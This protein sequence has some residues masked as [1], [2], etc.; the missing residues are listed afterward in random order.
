MSRQLS[1]PQNED[2]KSDPISNE[3]R[4]TLSRRD[5]FR[6]LGAGVMMLIPLPEADAQRPG[7]GRR[8]RGNS[9]PREI[10]AWI[11][12]AENGTVTVYSGK[13]EVGQN[14]RTSLTQA[15]AEELRIPVAAIQMVLGDTD[16]TP[17]D[18]GTF[19]S[20]TTPTMA[21]QLHRAAAAAREAIIGLAAQQWQVD[22]STIVAV[23]G[24]VVHSATNQ[25][26]GYGDVVKGQR[27]TQTIDDSVATTSAKDWKV[28][29]TSVPKVD[30]RDFVTGRHRY[31][32]DVKRDGM[33][34]GKVLR[35]TAF[36]A[37][38][39][40]IDIQA[41]SAMPGITVAHDG[42][43][44]GVVGPT[45]EAATRALAAIHAEWE[46]HPQP[47]D[48][49]LFS[50]LR[51]QA[52][53]PLPQ[54]AAGGAHTLQATYTVAYIAHAPL[55]PRTAVADWTGDRLTVWTGSQ[56]P[57]G[58]RSDL[59]NQLGI[60][61][62]RV[63]VIVPDTGSGYGG[64][65]SVGA[66]TEAARL[67]KAAGKPVKV[68]WTREEEFTWAYFR[69]AGVIDVT[70][71]VSP[72]GLLTEWEFY[73]YNS[74]GPGIRSPYN[75]P[76]QR[77]EA[78]RA[79]S[80][81]TQGSYRA[82]AA[83]ANHFA[84][85]SHMDDLAHAAGMDPV[86]FRLKNLND[87]R[88]H[89]VINAAADH[90]GWQNRKR[91]AGHGSG[92]AAGTEKGS[93]L[94]NCVEVLANAKTGE[95]KVTRIVSAFEC[96]AIVNPNH[97]Q[98]QVEGATV[99]GMGGALWEAIRFDNGRILNPHFAEYRVPRFGDVPPIEVVLLDRKD[100][101]SSG[102]GETPIVAIAPAI[103][104]AIFDATGIRLRHMPMIPNG[105]KVG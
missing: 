2:A 97:L 69:P 21:P 88:L 92:I 64:K 76:N 8:P 40:T 105:L 86:A 99:M 62:D 87:D 4:A 30:G 65:H 12:I 77:T 33:L 96:G 37:G 1:K 7:G 28:A 82:L 102:A 70:A 18:M 67:A 95:V 16:L 79:D 73:N 26:L 80:P 89:A 14:I 9:G 20:R 63:R 22:R 74:G 17:Y 49:A 3:R 83:T 24:K 78:R 25:A 46:T 98:N 38:L 56:R 51:P 84:R 90:F 23:D 13:A 91:A 45:T 29:G 11:H 35:P 31:A 5:L 75:I 58:I 27:L 54:Q 44:V 103:G 42:D 57:F 19:G 68:L 47:S 71:T 61:E 52:P 94:A 36:N 59:A 10:G 81:L 39:K 55:E 104:N 6:L 101:E 60:P 50:L 48:Q 85:E 72:D 15:V 66:A 53:A 43:F 100:L 32:S 41:A 93:Y 34:H